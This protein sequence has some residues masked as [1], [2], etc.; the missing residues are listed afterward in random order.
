L[1]FFNFFFLKNAPTFVFSFFFP[2]NNNNFQSKLTTFS[3]ILSHFTINLLSRC[4]DSVIFFHIIYIF[5][6]NGIHFPKFP[7][8]SI[9]KFNSNHQFG[10]FLC[11]NSFVVMNRVCILTIIL[12]CFLSFQHCSIRTPFFC[13]IIFIISFLG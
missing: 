13:E 8:I 12:V 3:P 10:Q 5:P 9:S 4:H 1:R 7:I 6:L 11:Y 2:N